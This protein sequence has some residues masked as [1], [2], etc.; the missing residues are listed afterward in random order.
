MCKF[1]RTVLVYEGVC[2]Y[3]RNVTPTSVVRE[4][5]FGTASGCITCRLHSPSTQGL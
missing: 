1:A 3:N 5:A 4:C 2:V